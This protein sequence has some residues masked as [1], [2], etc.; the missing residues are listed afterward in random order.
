M[1]RKQDNYVCAGGLNEQNS[2]GG[3]CRLSDGKI[4]TFSMFEEDYK[5]YY[6]SVYESFGVSPGVLIQFLIQLPFEIPFIDGRCETLVNNDKSVMSF[7]FSRIE[8]D[9]GYRYGLS[10]NESPIRKYFSNVEMTIG[11]EDTGEATTEIP[12]EELT[13]WFDSLLYVLN[14]LIVAYQVATNDEDA[15]IITKEMLPVCIPGRV[16]IVKEWTGQ[17]NFLFTL[18]LNTPYEKPRLSPKQEA[19]IM[20]HARIIFDS[21]NPFMLSNYFILNAK[22]YFKNGFYFET[23]IYAQIGIETFIRVLYREFLIEE[24][25][26][27]AEILEILENTAFMTI[28]KKEISK[29]IGGTWD[30]SRI[31]SAVGKWYSQTY[32]LRNRV[33]HG[34]YIPNQ[35]EAYDAI[36]GAIE[37]KRYVIELIDKKRNLYPKV[38]SYYRKENA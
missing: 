8:V 3:G 27:E 33:V 20:R 26:S 22:R 36:M 21:M 29:R 19:E 13:R 17:R 35:D 1:N 38:G 9:E 18:H 14:M 7:R 24:E 6:L 31:D 32:S 34:G 2:D 25:Y 11:V 15:Y 37:L 5:N 12:E 10:Q 28:I 4:N 23:V 30:T 16:I